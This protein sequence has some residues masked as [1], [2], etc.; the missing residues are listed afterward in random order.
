MALPSNLPRNN[1]VEYV[2]P[3]ERG[4][5]RHGSSI[6]LTQGFRSG[7]R[8]SKRRRQKK[9]KRQK[10][11][12]RKGKRGKKCRR[13]RMRLFTYDA[14]SNSNINECK[15][16]SDIDSCRRIKINFMRLKAE[17]PITLVDKNIVYKHLYTQ[18]NRDV[19]KTFSYETNDFDSAVFVASVDAKS[20]YPKLDGSFT[21]GGSKYLIDNCKE[22]C[23]VLIKLGSKRLHPKPDPVIDKAVGKMAV[24]QVRPRDF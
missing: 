20:G 4:M 7:G 15:R 11:K 5:A 17:K 14:N 6:S 10:K 21:V 23:H 9:K 8:R 22:N 13:R 19:T 16:M 1:P 3:G 24:S 2:T 12:C 18:L